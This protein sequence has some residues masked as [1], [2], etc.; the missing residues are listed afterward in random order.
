MPPSPPV[1]PLD[2]Q[3]SALPGSGFGE[4]E[5]GNLK[6]NKAH[7]GVFPASGLAEQNHQPFVCLFLCLSQCPFP[8]GCLLRA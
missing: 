8:L 7:T 6:G 5:G 3:P 2:T 1:K 4:A